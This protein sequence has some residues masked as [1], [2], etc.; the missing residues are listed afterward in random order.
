MYAVIFLLL[1]FYDLVEMYVP[2]GNYWDEL[3]AFAV[4]CWGIC[5]LRR[6]PKLTR[7]E[8]T[9]WLLLI[10]LVVIGA[11]G[12][13]VRPGL[14]PNPVAWI[15]DVVA[16]CKFPLI[17]LVLERRTVSRKKQE[18]IIAGAAKLSRWIVAGTVLA[19]VLGRPLTLFSPIPPFSSAPM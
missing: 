9:N 15:K 7:E 17:F 5:S 3:T 13:L 8:R 2:M 14:Q 6:G 18:Q 12:T 1:V 16:L 11:L 10:F 19:V 4:F